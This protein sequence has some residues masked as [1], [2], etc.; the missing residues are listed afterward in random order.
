MEPV[1]EMNRRFNALK[2]KLGIPQHMAMEV[3]YNL[4]TGDRKYLQ[5]SKETN[6]HLVKIWRD[7][8]K[9]T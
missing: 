7:S 1:S 2:R 8:I 6:R 5:I 4:K 9:E 3:G